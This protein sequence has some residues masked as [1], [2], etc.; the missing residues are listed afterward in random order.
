MIHQILKKTWVR[1]FIAGGTSYAIE[2]VVLFCLHHFLG[3]SAVNSVAISFWVGFFMAFTLQKIIT[4]QNYHKHPKILA[5]QLLSYSVLVGFNYFF[6]LG[7]VWIF[8]PRISVYI[9]RTIAILI[10]T[11]WNF[12]IYRKIFRDK[13]L[14]GKEAGRQKTTSSGESE[15]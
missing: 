14:H 2:M 11:I 6:T 7:L 12:I 8:T 1:Y 9:I 5:K 4:F 3:L 13:G 10:I 15:S